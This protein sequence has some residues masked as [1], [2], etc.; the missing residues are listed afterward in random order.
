MEALVARLADRVD[1]E[2]AGAV[3][4]D[5]VGAAL[6]HRHLVD[7][8]RRGLRRQR[9]EQRQCDVD[10]VEEVGVVLAAAA[11]ARTAHVVLGVLDAG[12]QLHQVAILLADRKRRDRL[13]GPTPRAPPTTESTSDASATTWISSVRVS[14]RG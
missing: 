5:R 9:A 2:A 14:T 6:D 3:E 4:V 12:N 7:V 10:A 8:V 11:G 1:R 13:R